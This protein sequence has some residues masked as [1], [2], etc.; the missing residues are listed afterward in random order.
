MC[1]A[2]SMKNRAV[3]DMIAESGPRLAELA[4]MSHSSISGQIFLRVRSCYTGVAYGWN[5]SQPEAGR[6]ALHSSL[7]TGCKSR[8]RR[9]GSGEETAWWPLMGNTSKAER[10][11]RQV[12]SCHV[13]FPLCRRGDDRSPQAEEGTG[14]RL[15]GSSCASFDLSWSRGVRDVS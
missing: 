15:P 1:T 4:V 6:E 3:V 11:V 5:E 12:L 7:F 2:R 13:S 14:L 9:R 10:R 8:G